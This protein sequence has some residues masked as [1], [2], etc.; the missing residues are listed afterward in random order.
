[1]PD[2]AGLA[3][4]LTDT[5]DLW[6]TGEVKI[7]QLQSPIRRRTFGRSRTKG[8]RILLQHRGHHI[9]DEKITAMEIQFRRVQRYIA[10]FLLKTLLDDDDEQG[11]GERVLKSRG[12][13]DPPWRRERRARRRQGPA[14][15]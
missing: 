11:V 2:N 6:T 13:W 15:R 10:R 3:R 14:R 4:F 9:E 5:E 8:E 12:E 1:M 7:F